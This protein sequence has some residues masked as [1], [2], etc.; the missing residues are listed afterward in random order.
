MR[1]LRQRSAQASSFRARKPPMLARPSFLA[2][3]VH[4]SASENISCAICFGVLSAWPAS[5]RL[6]K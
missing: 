1:R 6:T 2:D 3:I 4:P 5:R